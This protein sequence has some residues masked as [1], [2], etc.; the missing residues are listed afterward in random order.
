MYAVDY[1]DQAL[2]AT[3]Q[4]AQLNQLTSAQLEVLSPNQIPSD[5]QADIV[6]ANILAPILIELAP[7]LIAHT[8]PTGQIIL[9]GLLTHQA[10]EVKQAY[11]PS[12]HFCRKKR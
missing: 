1:D 6:I 12:L 10:P 5:L 2:Y 7:T 4:N 9:A 11:Q 8:Q 3:Q